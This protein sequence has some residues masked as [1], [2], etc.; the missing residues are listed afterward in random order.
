MFILLQS[1]GKF[2][3]VYFYIIKLIVNDNVC[4]ISILLQFNN[5]C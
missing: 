1:I 2:K 4:I 5:W 3:N